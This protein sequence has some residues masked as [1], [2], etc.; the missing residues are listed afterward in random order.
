M[1]GKRLYLKTWSTSLVMVGWVLS[2]NITPGCGQQIAVIA[3]QIGNQKSRESG[4]ILRSKEV[5]KVR[6]SQEREL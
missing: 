5:R 6:G 3:A 4:V 2:L 1:I